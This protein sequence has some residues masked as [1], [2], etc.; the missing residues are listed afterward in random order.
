MS[1]LALERACSASEG[2]DV[3]GELLQEHGQGGPCSEE[4]GKTSFA[5]HNSFLIADPISAWVLETAGPLWA[6]EHITGSVSLLTLFAVI[7]STEFWKFIYCIYHVFILVL[8]VYKS[9]VRPAIFKG[10]WFVAWWKMRLGFLEDWESHAKR[11][12]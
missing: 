11:I 3:I 7:F 4:P 10:T 6:A 8:S 9:Y 2:V 5:Y 1:R 12:A